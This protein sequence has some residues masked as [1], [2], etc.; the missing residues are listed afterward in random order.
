[1]NNQK[2]IENTLKETTDKIIKEI[3]EYQ[4]DESLIE[5]QGQC[6]RILGIPHEKFKKLGD[7]VEC[8]LFFGEKNRIPEA[9]IKVLFR[10]KNLID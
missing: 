9:E 3:I 4:L 8:T 5:N 7:L 1:M 6:A 10:Q 2:W